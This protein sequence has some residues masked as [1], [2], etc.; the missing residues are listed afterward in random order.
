MRAHFVEV[1]VKPECVDAFK[2]ATGANARGSIQ[3]PLV[4]R[5]DCYQQHD[6]P[7]KFILVE[8]FKN[9]DGPAAHKQTEHYKVWKETVESMM[10]EPRKATRFANVHPDDDQFENPAG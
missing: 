5:F 1:H 3:E 6:D 4:A 2:E 7:A 10:A 8:V 9:D